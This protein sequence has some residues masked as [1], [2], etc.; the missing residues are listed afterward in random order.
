MFS[1]TPLVSSLSNNINHV[2]DLILASSSDTFS[3]IISSWPNILW[4]TWILL[5]WW[6]FWSLIEKAITKL[7]SSTRIEKLF[8]K[9]Q[10]QDVL[11]KAQ[12][13]IPPVLIVVKFLKWYIFMMF[14]LAASNLLGLTY[15][16]E[17]LDSVIAFLPKVVVALFIVLLWFRVAN[18]TWIFLLNTLKLADLKTALLLSTVAKYIIITFTILAALMQIEIAPE[19]LNILFIWIVS[20]LSLWMWLSFWIGWSRYIA[21]RLEEFSIK[22][23]K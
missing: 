3:T 15:I 5:I 6:I 22:N 2:N 7:I 18:T 9:L 11:S 8:D 19:F 17:F 1:F 21:N 13:K 20:A 16:S 23:K 10:F 12:I 4:A 14:F